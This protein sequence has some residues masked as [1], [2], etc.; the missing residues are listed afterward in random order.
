MGDP[1]NS[2]CILCMFTP[3]SDL[4]WGAIIGFPNK[5]S[6]ANLGGC[7]AW[8]D[9]DAG[10][11]SCAAAE[12]SRELCRHDSCAA[13][14]PIA[15]TPLALSAFEQCQ[16]E[17]DTTVCAKEFAAAQ[18]DEAVRYT[19]CLFADFQAYFLAFGQLFCEANMDGGADAA[20]DGTGDAYNAGPDATPD[21]APD[22]FAPGDAGDGG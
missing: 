18:C 8:L 3:S 17:A 20:L 11:G 19:P 9:Q 16:A 12:Q 14:C 7:L 6:E 5:T 2:P 21:A 13:A 22:A 1:D 4:A 15:S 10:P